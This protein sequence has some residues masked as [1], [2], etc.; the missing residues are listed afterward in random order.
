MH[1]YNRYELKQCLPYY[2]VGVRLKLGVNIKHVFDV[3]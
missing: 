3:E 2:A 1:L